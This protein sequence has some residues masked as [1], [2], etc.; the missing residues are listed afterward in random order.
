MRT[1]YRLS[2]RFFRYLFVAL[3]AIAVLAWIVWLGFV[4]YFFSNSPTHKKSIP[5]RNERIEAEQAERLRTKAKEWPIF[6]AEY[7]CNDI[8][9]GYIVKHIGQETL[10]LRHY[11][12]PFSE[13]VCRLT[14][15]SYD[16]TEYVDGKVVRGAALSHIAIPYFV[17]CAEQMFPT[18]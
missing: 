8:P 9:E 5:T 10:S 15:D 16:K 2:I 3:V 12:Q 18:R 6:C 7:D 1:N 17:Q 11:A 13:T 14:T 4:A